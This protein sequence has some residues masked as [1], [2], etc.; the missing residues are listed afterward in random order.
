MARVRDKKRNSFYPRSHT[1]R[2]EVK[3]SNIRAPPLLVFLAQ[4]L[5]ARLDGPADDDYL[6]QVAA[7]LRR[8]VNVHNVGR[9]EARVRDEAVNPLAKHHERALQLLPVV[10]GLPRALTLV[11][12]LAAQ[13]QV[14]LHP[15]GTPLHLGGLV[16][17][18][19]VVEDALALDGA[20]Y[21]VSYDL[22][23]FE[24]LVEL[25]DGDF[26]RPL[27]RVRH[28]GL[29]ATELHLALLLVAYA[30]RLRVDERPRRDAGRGALLRRT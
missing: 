29:D 11:R 26:D 4:P 8:P 14:G 21:V 16:G 18:A 13:R 9:R 1:K 10:L 25:F 30:R 7:G 22:D 20:G 27:F 5:G 19:L 24:V 12:V 17:D 2:H 15:E 23:S 3:D 28:L 6:L